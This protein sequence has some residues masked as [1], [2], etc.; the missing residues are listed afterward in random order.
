MRLIPLD[1]GDLVIRREDFELAFQHL[2]LP[3][4]DARHLLKS[5][6]RS[7]KEVS[8]KS[9]SYVIIGAFEGEPVPL[10]TDR[11]RYKD[12][13]NV[14]ELAKATP[15]QFFQKVYHDLPKDGVVYAN[16]LG[17]VDPPLLK[18]MRNYCSNHKIDLKKF[19]QPR[20]VRP[21][22]TEV[23]NGAM[24]VQARRTTRRPAPR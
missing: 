3:A 10:P 5:V 24:S 6:T 8:V 20:P 4:L 11:T 1:R 7:L 19:V 12:K 2:E 16:Q 23:A 21:V 22:L 13:H 18:A 17:K 9:A 15:I 14:R